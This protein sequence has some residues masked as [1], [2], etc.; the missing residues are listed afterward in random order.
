[1]VHFLLKL[2][3]ELCTLK[4]VVCLISVLLA[5]PFGHCRS[6]NFVM[7]DCWFISVFC[8]KLDSIS[9]LNP[10]QSPQIYTLNL[11]NITCLLS[12]RR[13]S[14]AVRSTFSQK[15]SVDPKGKDYI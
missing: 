6:D 13:R 1:M 14:E 5:T 7:Y 2:S 3:T 10:Q 9:K 4:P 11:L 8:S 12:C 15:T